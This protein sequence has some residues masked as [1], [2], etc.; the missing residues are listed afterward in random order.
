MEWYGY[1][2]TD[3]QNTFV[4]IETVSLL[5]YVLNHCIYVQEVQCKLSRCT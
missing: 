1:K 5:P 4:Y 3:R 2:Q